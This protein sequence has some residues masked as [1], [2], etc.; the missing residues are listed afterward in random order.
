[1]ITHENSNF[2]DQLSR[3]RH[4]A[5][6]SHFRFNMQSFMEHIRVNSVNLTVTLPFVF[7]FK[8]MYKSL[9]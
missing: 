7:T 8:H 6:G 3:T 5:Y 2:T 1:M 9:I 4:V